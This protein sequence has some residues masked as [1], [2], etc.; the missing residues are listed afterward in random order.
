MPNNEGP[1]V[2]KMAFSKEALTLTNMDGEDLPKLVNS[3]VVKNYYPNVLFLSTN[4]I[5]V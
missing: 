4:K 1:Y 3:D 2:C 5:E